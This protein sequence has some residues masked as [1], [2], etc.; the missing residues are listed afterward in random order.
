MLVGSVLSGRKVS[1]REVLP[2]HDL[3]SC[4]AV[5]FGVLRE[6]L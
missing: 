5:Q 2:I 4:Q 3:L 6:P 1:W